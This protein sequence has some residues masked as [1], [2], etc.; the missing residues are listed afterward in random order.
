LCGS[1]Q[2]ASLVVVIIVVLF[3]ARGR[4]LRGEGHARFGQN[5][6]RCTELARSPEQLAVGCC[7]SFLV[8]LL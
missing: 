3:I 1:I 6:L 2:I 7:M 8:L 5:E 4:E